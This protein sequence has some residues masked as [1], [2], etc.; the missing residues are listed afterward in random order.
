MMHKIKK[1]ATNSKTVENAEFVDYK[2]RLDM[3]STYLRESSGALKESEKTWQEVCN[4]EKVFADKFALRYPDKDSIRDFA[5]QSSQSSQKLVKNFVLKSESKSASHWKIDVIVQDYIKEINDIQN[6]YRSVDDLAKEVAMYSK[7][8]EDLQNS[9][10][11]NKDEEKLSRNIEKLNDSREKYEQGLDT[12]VDKM[13]HIYDKRNIALKATFVAYWSS[14]LRAFNMIDNSLDPIREFVENSVED[15]VAIKIR[16]MTSTDIEQFRVEHL[17]V[18]SDGKRSNAS[19]PTS[20][21]SASPTM[22]EKSDFPTSPVEGEAT[23]PADPPVAA[24]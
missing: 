11:K 24:V 18:D 5:K 2:N 3:I 8:V 9:K 21:A 16:S 20:N 10:K 19:T 23:T 1:A 6:E 17:Q 7:K 12:I 4:T 15:L 13:K 14:Q 22:A